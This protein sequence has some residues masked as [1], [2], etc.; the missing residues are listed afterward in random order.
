MER[1]TGL[2]HSVDRT[3]GIVFFAIP[4]SLGYIKQLVVAAIPAQDIIQ[5]PNARAGS[6]F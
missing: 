6:F 3:R 4:L 2:N 5:K 1:I